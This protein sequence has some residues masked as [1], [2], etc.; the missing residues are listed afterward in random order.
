MII[1]KTNKALQKHLQSSTKTN[2]KIGFV[3]TMGALHNGHIS[4]IENSI[5]QQLYTV[6]S[7]FVNPTQFNSA[8][9]FEKYPIT[10]TTDI[11][12]LE[13]AGCH[14]LFLPIVTEIYPNNYVP[15]YYELG[16]LETVLE[17][18]YRPGHFQGVCQVV[19]I[20][21]EL[22]QPHILFLGQK[23][24]QQ[25]MVINKLI[26]LEQLAVQLQIVPTKR[27]ETGL[28]LSSR[29]IR[30]SNMGLQNATAI[31]RCFAHIQ[32]HRQL[33]TIAE[34]QQ[35]CQQI[36]LHN[37]FTHIDYVSFCDTTSLLEFNASY[38]PKKFVVL[39]AAFLEEVRLI[40]NTV[41]E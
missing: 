22:V 15:K 4:L 17:G 16:F 28:A 19:H 8:A 12:A 7:I 38:L 3:P 23:D 10:I 5:Q 34:L 24:Y 29:N 39:I 9:D 33:A 27:A 18:K 40:D 26:E 25:C 21:L 32:L 41:F 2:K 30:L 37:N 6:C 13:K 35:Q 14:V 1:L 36:L 20:L 11:L 31:Y